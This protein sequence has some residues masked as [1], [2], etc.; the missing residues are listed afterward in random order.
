EDKAEEGNINY[1]QCRN[2]DLWLN[3]N[4]YIKYEVKNSSGC[5]P[6]LEATIKMES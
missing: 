3:S 4:E 1:E 6:D 2:Y 5:V